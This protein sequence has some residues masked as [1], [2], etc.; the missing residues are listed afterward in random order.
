[1][2]EEK[3]SLRELV[4]HVS[5]SPDSIQPITYSELA[6][7]IGRL[8]KH[9]VGHGHGMG[10]VLGKMGHLFDEIQDEWQDETPYIQSLVVDK[11][12][13]LKGLPADGI[14]M[15]WPKYPSLSK[16]EKENRAQAEYLKIRQYGS[17]WNRVLEAL[18]IEPIK[19]IA[20]EEEL[21]FPGNPIRGFGN[22]GES[23][24]HLALKNYI[25]E[26]PAIVGADDNYTAFTEYALPSLDTLD[27]LFKSQDKWVAVEVKSRISD[28]LLTDYERG[29]YQCIKYQALLEAMTLDPTYK[30]PKVEVKLVLENDLPKQYKT[31]AHLLGVD[32][33]ANIKP[34]IAQS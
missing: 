24:F 11:A 21:D 2:T 28:G 5:R 22:G 10:G 32:V 13:P 12:G 34:I 26:N 23:K 9:G 8:N 7:R 16:K 18:G 20:P 33:I 19:S 4:A 25:A 3:S 17:R 30:V 1:M 6:K 27:V 31:T 29:I 15:F 14:E